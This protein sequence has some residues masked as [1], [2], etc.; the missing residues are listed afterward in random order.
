MSSAHPTG[1]RKSSGAG[2]G[3]TSARR[4]RPLGRT[5]CRLGTSLSSLA[6]RMRAV[7]PA[8]RSS[9]LAAEMPRSTTHLT[10]RSVCRWR[11]T[12]AS[13]CHNHDRGVRCRRRE[14]SDRPTRS[15]G[16]TWPSDDPDACFPEHLARGA[17]DGVDLFFDNVGGRQLTLALSVLRDFGSVVLR[18]SNSG[19]ASRDDPDAGADL[20]AAVLKRATLARLR[21]Q[22]P[23]CAPADPD[24]D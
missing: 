2:I 11:R 4:G 16:S 18:G 15:W 1:Q 21:R 14:A 8:R 6:A 7:V 12:L 22:R 10:C 3:Q 9:W 19:Y 17:D 20:T 23:L 24:S 13:A 5:T